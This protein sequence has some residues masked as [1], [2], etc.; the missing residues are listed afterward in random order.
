GMRVLRPALPGDPAGDLASWYE[1]CGK[2]LWQAD[3]AADALC[4]VADVDVV[5]ADERTPGRWGASAEDLA[6][7]NPNAIVC[8]IT[9]FGQDGPRAAELATEATLQ[10]TAGHLWLTGNEDRPPVPLAGNQSLYQASSQAAV[11]IVAALYARNV[12]GH[13]GDLLD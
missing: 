5:I 1:D 7:R 6:E 13:G 12:H 4:Y 2:D 11:A 9:P 8:M 10:A 3:V